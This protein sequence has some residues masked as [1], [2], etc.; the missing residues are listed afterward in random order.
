MLT[1]QFNL[2]LFLTMTASGRL[3][4]TPYIHSYAALSALLSRREPV[5]FL[6]GP[7]LF[8]SA[9]RNSFA[10]VALLSAGLFSASGFLADMADARPGSSG[11]SGS[12]GTRTFTPPAA[13]QTAPGAAAPIQ[14]SITQPGAIAK[15][16]AAAATAATAAAATAA[17]PSMMR[18][19]L[20][21]GLMGAGLAMMFGSGPMAGILGFILQSLL[22]A[23][24]I[25]LAVMFFRGRF[26]SKPATATA[27]PAPASRPMQQNANLRQASMATGGGAPAAPAMKLSDADFS[28][29]EAVLTTIQTA[30]GRGD[31]DA[32]GRRATPE[33][34][35][36]FAHELDDNKRKGVVNE[37]SAPKLLQGDLSESWREAGS[38]FA[39][40]AMR[41]SL[42]DA[43]VETKTGRVVA[44]NRT[45][46]Q[47]VTEIWTFRRNPGQG[48][49]AWEL[50]AI[51]QTV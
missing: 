20:L 31:L 22:I 41:Y 21:G 19:L 45:V 6:E 4:I 28:A 3:T 32:L 14:R 5:I 50:S 16:P 48:P 24:I 18:N 25:Y 49:D 36:Y 12:R 13:T 46:P 11:S 29:F 23:G 40:V 7:M 27:A 37:I 35:S 15:A 26:G 38:E 43:T 47:E 51:Q 2:K 44:G 30:Y 10:A 33:M 39:T 34:L 9:L 1:K 8:R 17:K 42:T